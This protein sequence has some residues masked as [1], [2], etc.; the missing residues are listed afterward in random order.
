[1]KA[2]YRSYTFTNAAIMVNPFRLW[3]GIFL[4]IILGVIKYSLAS[5]S[6]VKFNFQIAYNHSIGVFF[7]A[8]FKILLILVG[9]PDNHQVA[10]GKTLRKIYGRLYESNL[11]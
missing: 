11:K 8:T 2:I 6:A 9:K 4:S 1:M 10:K 7:F 3:P 5:T